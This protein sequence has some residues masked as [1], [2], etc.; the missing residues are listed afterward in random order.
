MYYYNILMT[1]KEQFHFNGNIGAK[2][3]EKLK[4]G[5]KVKWEGTKLLTSAGTGIVM[6]AWDSEKH[7]KNEYFL[8]NRRQADTYEIFIEKIN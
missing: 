2:S 5:D 6:T 3:P 1:K 4:K 8:N 7:R